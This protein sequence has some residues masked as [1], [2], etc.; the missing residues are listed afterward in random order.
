MG[1]PTAKDIDV[2]AL[3]ELLIDFTEYGVSDQ[4]NVTFEA[5]PGGAPCNLLAMLAKLGKK[6]AFIGKVG[7]DGFGHLLGDA[8]EEQGIDISS[9]IYDKD[10]HTTLAFVHKLPD[11]DRDFSFYRGP[12]ADMMLRKEE[13][14]L[15]LIRRAKIFHFGS[16]S[17]TDEPART[18][19][20]EALKIAEKADCLISFDPNLRPP[21]W[22]DLDLAK[23]Q[24][25]FGLQHTDVLKI[26]D[27]EIQWFTGEQDFDAAVDILRERY[28]QIRLICVSLG[29]DGSIAYYKGF[30]FK[31][32]AFKTPD[33][34][35]T[36][37]AGDCFGACILNYLLEHD[38]D[39]LTPGDLRQMLVFAN[40]AA[41]VV[42]T[43]K[44][45][46]RM[47]PTEQEVRDVIRAHSDK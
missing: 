43:W 47:M 42:T 25:A 9:L 2:T 27:N 41:S 5:N 26:A 20:R 4:W 8:V 37:G 1:T 34:V 36:T 13:I 33:T 3:G 10:V 14:D 46:L 6:T 35:E 18:A 7:E 19:T 40:A 32:P 44:G 16:L 22:K 29:P 31:V 11:G 21:L 28:P 38:I 45:A 17:L 15:D 39:D 30:K 23:E 12:G 24:I